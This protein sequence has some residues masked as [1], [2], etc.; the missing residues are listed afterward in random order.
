MGK[1][2]SLCPSWKPLEICLIKVFLNDLVKLL[3]RF[4]YEFCFQFCF[5]LFVLPVC[6]FLVLSMLHSS[7]L[8][9]GIHVVA[10]TQ[11]NINSVVVSKRDVESV[12]LEPWIA[13]GKGTL[14]L[15]LAIARVCQI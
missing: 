5:R 1:S 3:A 7:H 6:L 4:G 10:S 8:V 14:P 9:I 15:L 11:Q 2:S 13:S 12:Q